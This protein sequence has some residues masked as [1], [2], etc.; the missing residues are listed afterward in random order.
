MRL[1]LV[2]CQK[3]AVAGGVL[4]AALACPAFAQ[5]S[6]TPQAESASQRASD[7]IVVTAQFREQNLQDTPI[8]ITAVDAATL[9]ARNQTSITDLGDFA[10]NVALEPATGLQGNSIAAFIR[11]I[12]QA[13]ASFALEPGVGV[14]IDDIYYGTTFGAVMDLTDLDRVEVLRGPQG[15]LAGKNSVGGAIK[16]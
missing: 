8:A 16:L 7:T 15:T 13:D 11:G 5:E 12:G 3:S 6:D 4:I 10:P 2:A 9:E 1:K 14:Y